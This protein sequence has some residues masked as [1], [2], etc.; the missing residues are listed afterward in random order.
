MRSAA[1]A[2]R[3]AARRWSSCLDDVHWADPASLDLLAALA[4]RPPE[5][6]VLLAV[7]YREGQAPDALVAALGDAARAAR[8]ERLAPAPLEPGRGGRAL[9][10][11]D[12]SPGAL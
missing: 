7:A 10:G 8:A 3:G 9:V 5:G 4:R 2:A 12:L 11:G 1:R 6:A